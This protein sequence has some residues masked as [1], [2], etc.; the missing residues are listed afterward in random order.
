MLFSTIS[1]N[2]QQKAIPCEDYCENLAMK[3]VEYVQTISTNTA[4]IT[5]PSIAMQ[6]LQKLPENL[7]AFDIDVQNLKRPF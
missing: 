6:F 3:M 2:V 7:R 4:T 1:Q 5:E